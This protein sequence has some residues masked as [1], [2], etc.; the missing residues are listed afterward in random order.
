MYQ[1]IYFSSVYFVCV[2]KV[3]QTN[4]LRHCHGRR[5]QLQLVP[6]VG[7]GSFFAEMPLYQRVVSCED[8][9]VDQLNSAF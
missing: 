8:L 7:A 6:G 1:N 2:N 4:S 3:V 9:H 5:G